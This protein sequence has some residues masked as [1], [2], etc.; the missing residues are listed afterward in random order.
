MIIGQYPCCNADFT[1]AV[2]KKTPAYLPEDCP[3]CG[4]K[5]WHVVSR[6]DPISYTEEEFLKLYDVDYEKKIVTRKSLQESVT[7]DYPLP[8]GA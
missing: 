2:P 7:N 6:V 5:V 4:V 1:L 8:A 3:H